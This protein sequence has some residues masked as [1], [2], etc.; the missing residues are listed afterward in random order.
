MASELQ[1]LCHS[2]KS[3]NDIDEPDLV[4]RVT[5]HKCDGFIGVY[6]TIQSASLSTKIKGCA[7]KFTSIVYDKERIEKALLKS[8]DGIELAR[9]YFP[10]SISDYKKEHSTP[11]DL[12]SETPHLNC[13]HCGAELIIEGAGI[14]CVL[15]KALP[16]TS[17]GF[18]EVDA[19]YACKGKCDRIL[20]RHYLSQGLYAI[21]WMEIDD[22]KI[23]TLFI[24]SLMA[25][26]NDMR[27][28]KMEPKAIN[29]LK[30]VFLNIYPHTA[31][32]LSEGEKK[33]VS[34]RILAS[35]I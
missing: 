12:Y 5:K 21:Q 2:G 33:T 23:P 10:K 32:E 22:L 14:F 18:K 17:N 27:E 29:K 8:V 31:R 24:K 11:A 16:E 20:E 13:D 1:T 9:R 3:V 26:I 4:D 28:N 15:Q 34:R 35:Y 6:S 25:F 7:E 19:Y 30:E